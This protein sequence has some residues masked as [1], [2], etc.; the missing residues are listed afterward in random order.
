MSHEVES[1]MW[2][3]DAPWHGLGTEITEETAFNINDCIKYSGLDW[4]VVLRQ[5]FVNYNDEELP[6]ESFATIRKSDSS[7]LGIV[8]PGYEVL[9]NVDAFKIFQP[10]LDSKL[11]RINTAGSLFCG[12]KI[13]V[14][15]EIVGDPIVIRQNDVIKKFILLSHGHDGKSAVRFGF[16]PT[17]VVCANTLQM[18]HE[19][20]LSKLFKV[21]HTKNMKDQLHEIRE[22]ISLI[23]A[24]FTI[25]AYNYEKL[26][27]KPMAPD[28]LDIYINKIFKVNG[29]EPST[30][31]YNILQKV[32]SY[33]TFA[34]GA[35]GETYWD[36]Y[37]AVTYYF[38]H[39]YGNNQENRLNNLWFGSSA[40]TCKRALQLALED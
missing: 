3:K 4:E 37:N 13:W 40:E 1:M 22:L 16:T 15:A 2:L 21:K 17:R 10:F 19:S 32:K 6:V 39:D 28:Q 38:T 25:T 33:F 34:P 24:E 14:L 35:R 8:G 5:C 23:N 30:R 11:V 27:Q 9:Q 20:N 26:S 18:A 12:Q 36:A 29:E 7:I 31:L